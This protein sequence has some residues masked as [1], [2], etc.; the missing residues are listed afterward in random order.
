MIKYGVVLRAQFVG[1]GAETGPTRDLYFKVLPKGTCSISGCLI[2]FPTLDVCPHGLGHSVVGTTHLF[3]ELGVALPRLELARRDEYTESLSTY[4]A[5]DGERGA[6]LFGRPCPTATEWCHLLYESK[7]WTGYDASRFP[8]AVADCHACL[9]PPGQEALIPA[10][11]DRPMAAGP[12]YCVGTSGTTLASALEALPGVCDGKEKI[13]M[14][15]VQNVGTET[16]TVDRGF[17][18]AYN[19]GTL[20]L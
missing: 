11:W 6:V 12:R 7:P 8:V 2:G 20:D 14:L 13:L 16:V 10:A 3:E 5:T 1:V 9:L 19:P 18:L 15:S 17:P 4:H